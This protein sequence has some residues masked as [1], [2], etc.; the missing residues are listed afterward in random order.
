[1]GFFNRLSPK[2]QGYVFVIITMMI[3]GSFS[4]LARLNASWGIVAWDIIAI[5]FS[6]S[7][8][9]LLPILIHQGNH[10]FLWSKKALLLAIFGGVGYSMLVYSAFLLAPVAHGAV[11]L[12]GMIPVATALL[13]LFWL[14]KRPDTDTKIALTI[15]SL[16]LVGMTALMISTG[17]TFGVG[18]GLFVLCAFSWGI[19]GILVKESTLSAWQVMCATA[20]WSAIIYLPLYGLFFEP[21]LSGVKPHH[22]LIQG[23]FHSLIVMIVAT[24]TYALAVARLG[25]FMA[26]GMA[27]IAPFMSA[28]IAVPLLGERLNEVMVLGLIGMALG[29][30]Q[31]WRF[32][33]FKHKEIS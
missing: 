29:T 27:S 1:M 20:I 12:N 9:I 6:V 5:R 28:I 25:A 22:L 11:F 2:T 7:A 19:Y 16:T 13:M 23:I 32:L 4:L 17:Q 30:V 33:K 10:H 15:I 26:G 24:M 3:W 8:L 21:A 14:K 31:P 18:D